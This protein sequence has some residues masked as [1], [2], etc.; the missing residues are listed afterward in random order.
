[1]RQIV[2][3]ALVAV[4]LVLVGCGSPAA[5]PAKEVEKPAT[6]EAIEGTDGL[7]RITLTQRAAERLGIETVEVAPASGVSGGSQIPYSSVFYDPQGDAWA[8]VVDSGPL[9]FV[10]QAITVSDIVV[11]PAGDYAVLT[12]GPDPGSHVVS[13]GVAE[14]F[15]AEFEVG[16]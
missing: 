1:M 3:T 2:A 16:H 4:A 12:D 6:V 5:D 10:R 15:G 7:H 14:L 13:V 11:H 9:V 8:Y